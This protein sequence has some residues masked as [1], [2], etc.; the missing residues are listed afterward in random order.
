VYIAGVGHSGST[1]LDIVTGTIPG[2]FSSGEITYLPS[3]MAYRKFPCSC[4]SPLA[5]CRV[6]SKVVADVSQEVGFDVRQDPLRYK[7]ALLQRQRW[8]TDLPQDIW[9]TLQRAV[10]GYAM[11]RRS[12]D[13]IEGIWRTALSE[14][15]DNNWRIFDTV[16]KT[17]DVRYVV[18][19]SK[20]IYRAK[21]LHS[22]RPADVYVLLLI[23][24][25]RGLAWSSIKRGRDPIRTTGKFVRQYNR[26]LSTLR[27]MEG[28]SFTPVK[29]ERL[30]AD[31]IAERRRIAGFLGL[32][33]PGADIEIDPAKHHL[34]GGNAMRMKGRMD[35]RLDESW[36]E[37]LTPDVRSR[38][39]KLA[40]RLDDGWQKLLDQ[41]YP[42]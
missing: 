34:T 5:E 26:I 9:F 27:N 17:C 39:E 16:C 2:V 19:S 14:R 15:I 8:K 6:W 11:Q 13:I 29:Y 42:E 18:D 4:L 35:I 36:K 32:D 38:V 41:A 21:L 23:R 12:L 31:P 33:D 3:R 24:D 30:C 7:M 10:F 40:S 28:V 22:K 20:N 37:N 25:L 1:L